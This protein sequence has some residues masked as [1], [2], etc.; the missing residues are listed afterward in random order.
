[1]RLP[2]T[3]TQKGSKGDFNVDLQ[4]FC[5]VLNLCFHSSHVLV[6]SADVAWSNWCVKLTMHQRDFTHLPIIARKMAKH[7]FFD[8]WKV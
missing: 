3:Q 4:R 5:S 6:V 8:K 1:M 7:L 2:E